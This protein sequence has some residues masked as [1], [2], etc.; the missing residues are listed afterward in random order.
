MYV[1]QIPNNLLSLRIGHG[2][3]TLFP[4]KG[5]EQNG[6]LEVRNPNI[7]LK[8][9]YNAKDKTLV[10][11]LLKNVNKEIRDVFQINIYNEI[12][13]IKRDIIEETKDSIR[14]DIKYPEDKRPIYLIIT[15]KEPK[16]DPKAIY[17]R[18][19]KELLM[20]NILSQVITIDTLT[21]P[22]KISESITFRNIAL[23]IF[24]KA[25]NIPWYLQMP[26]ILSETGEEALIIGIG[27]TSF[28]QNIFS[29]E[30]H[31]YVGYF[32]FFNSRG[33]WKTLTPLFSSL[34][35]I[36]EKIQQFLIE[37]INQTIS[38]KVNELDIIIHYTGKDVKKDEEKIIHDA[39]TQYSKDKGIRINYT[40]VRLIK[41]PVYRLF[42]NYEDGYAYMGTYIDFE[43][44]LILINTTGLLGKNAT[45]MGVNTPI[46]AS[47]RKTN[48]E[49]NS[50]IVHNIVYSIVGLA[51]MNWRGVNPFNFEPATTKYA[52][53]IAYTLAHF[54][55]TI[56]RKEH[57]LR[58]LQNKLWFI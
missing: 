49:I 56:Y 35:E 24:V 43:N 41:S 8:V 2:T 50:N 53:E 20:N 16:D 26:I 57:V 28:R 33:I 31:R 45:P 47:I 25:G 42:S 30:I 51:R 46:L 23:G 14:E 10:D 21:D 22:R 7:F 4:N 40:M 55:E 37:G 48:L 5:L 18:I 44:G 17:Y 19:K 29:N 6:P 9:I 36:Q 39:L 27:I 38:N 52:R 13:E 58:F 12:K 32:S 54:D 3:S 1:R 11:N 34:N 15:K